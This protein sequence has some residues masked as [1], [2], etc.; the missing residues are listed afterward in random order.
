MKIDNYNMREVQKDG[1]TLFSVTTDV[2]VKRD[3][4]EQRVLSIMEELNGVQIES[5]E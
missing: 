4:Y 3:K 2:I 5:I 1:T